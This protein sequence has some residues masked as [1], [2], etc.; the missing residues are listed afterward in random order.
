MFMPLRFALLVGAAS[1]ILGQNV[2]AQALGSIPCCAAAPDAV[3]AVIDG[4]SVRVRDL[5]AYS[6]TDDPR[7]LFLLNRQLQ[8]SR[9]ELLDNVNDELLLEAEAARHGKTVSR[10]LQERLKVE[11]VTD[12]A[13]LR[14]FERIKEQQ[15]T[16]SYEQ[17]QPTIRM[18][19]EGQ[20]RAKAKAAYIKEL[21]QAVR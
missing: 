15:P 12:A 2:M 20:L 17:M 13:I 5:D 8:D 18:F 4:E 10:L 6:R 1:L 21:K 11:R 14:T 7:K 3:A 19:L 9:R 16:I